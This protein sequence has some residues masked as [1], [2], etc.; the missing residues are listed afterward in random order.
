[1][2]LTVSLGERHDGPRTSHKIT[3]NHVLPH[4]CLLSYVLYLIVTLFL[5]L[6]FIFH[7]LICFRIHVIIIKIDGAILRPQTQLRC[8]LPLIRLLTAFS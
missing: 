5:Y 2:L 8:F 7:I 1:M 4:K 3:S 6:T